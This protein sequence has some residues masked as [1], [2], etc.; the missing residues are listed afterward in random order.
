L[1]TESLVEEIS[2]RYALGQ[3][4]RWRA[5]GGSSTTNLRLDLPD[6]RSLV[7]RLHG[8]G[9]STGRLA[10]LQ[11]ARHAAAAAGVP[12][13][14]SVPA[15]DGRSYARLTGGLL[16]EVE[17]HVAHDDRMNRMPLLEQG[18]RVLGRLH[19]A[20]R[21]ADLPAEAAV[22]PHANALDPAEAVSAARR[23]QDRI[24]GWGEP[25]LAAFAERA[26]RHL[27][28]VAAAEEPL[29]RAQQWQVVHGD[30]W[31]NNVLIHNGVVV[32]VIDFDFLGRRPRI[33]DLALTAFFFLL[34]P[35]LTLPS[36][37]DR[38][39]IAS[40]VAAYDRGTD[41]PLSPDERAALPLAIARQP[42][43]S[44]G[45]HV[46]ELDEEPARAHARAAMAELPVAEAIMAELP[47]WQDV[48]R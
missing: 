31:D 40:M 19:D 2:G 8:A 42:A 41:Q 12:V 18:M 25:D 22:A 30:F 13:V 34:E 5:L 44:I 26:V 20:L 39:A 16:V 23:G 15:L 7:A 36:A 27:D 38:D 11:A 24:T 1:T 45:R 48:L 9:T 47:A 37:D 33:D 35:P 4:L 28:F 32:A 46:V 43:W 6:G 3:P 29:R 10:A 17:P 14:L 21:D